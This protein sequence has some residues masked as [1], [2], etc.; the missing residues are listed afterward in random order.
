MLGIQ[1]KDKLSCTYCEILKPKTAC[2]SSWK[3]LGMITD[4][5]ILMNSGLSG[6]KRKYGTM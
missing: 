5:F 1:V 4:L 2:N 3:L 6:K